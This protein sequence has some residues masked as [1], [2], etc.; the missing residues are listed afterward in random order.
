MMTKSLLSQ[1]GL[2]SAFLLLNLLVCAFSAT[3]LLAE[4]NGLNTSALYGGDVG[5]SMEE[6]GEVNSPLFDE[7]Y[8]DI[9]KEFWNATGGPNWYPIQWDFVGPWHT[10]PHVSINDEGT[11]DIE[12]RA[13]NLRG[14]IPDSFPLIRLSYLA[15]SSNLLS[16]TIPDTFCTSNI[17]SIFLSNNYIGGTLPECLGQLTELSTLS[18]AQNAIEG[19]IPESIYSCKKLDYLVLN[20]NLLTGTLSSGIGGLKLLSALDLSNNFLTGTLPFEITLATSLQQILLSNNLFEGEI[21]RDILRSWGHHVSKLV[22]SDNRFN[23]SLYPFTHLTNTTVIALARNRFTGPLMLIRMLSKIAYLDISGNGMNGTIDPSDFL[24]Y[25]VSDLAY[26]NIMGNNL[27]PIDQQSLQQYPLSFSGDTQLKTSTENWTCKTI[28]ARLI[29]LT[30]MVDPSFLNYS[31][32]GCIRGYFGHPPDNCFP[33]PIDASYC[34][35]GTMLDIPSGSIPYPLPGKDDVLAGHTTPQPVYFEAC[36]SP[37]SCSKKCSVNLVPSPGG[38]RF[39]PE[40][41]ASYGQHNNSLCGCLPGHSGRKCSHCVCDPD[42][43]EGPSCYYEAAMHCRKCSSVWSEKRT[44]AT[45]ISIAFV[46]LIAATITHTLVLRSKRRFTVRSP[47]MSLWKRAIYRILHVRAVGYFKILIIWIQTLAAIVSWRSDV[48][49]RVI[50]F[51]DITNGNAGGIGITCLWPALRHR[52]ISYLARILM[53]FALSAILAISIFFAHFIWNAFFR[54]KNATFKAKKSL[55]NSTSSMDPNSASVSSDS[56]AEQFKINDPAMAALDDGDIALRSGVSESDADDLRFQLTAAESESE[57]LLAQPNSKHSIRYYSARGLIVSE[58]LTVL[59]FF[60]FGV[61]LNS[62]D[63]FPCEEQSGTHVVFL[64]ALPWLRCDSRELRTL[65]ILASP[66]LVLYTLGVPALFVGI[67]LYYRK[68][69]HIR[70]VNDIIGGLYRCYRSSCYGWDIVVL[71]RRF[72]LAL[73]LRI[74]LVTVFH[75]WV[76][77]L[78]LTGSLALQFWFQPFRRE[79]ENRAEEVSLLLLMLTY[80][81]QRDYDTHG[82][83]KDTHA[84]FWVTVL[85]NILFAVSI[86]GLIIHAWWTAKVSFDEDDDLMRENLE[87][88]AGS[89]SF[90]VK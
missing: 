24:L 27:R 34:S 4:A 35:T 28:S 20:G 70:V 64:E 7:A 9:L 44:A 45:G 13:N 17:T 11:V 77:F 52:W 22:L 82:Q 59:Y 67:L 65:R 83:H 23:G 81:A 42:N 1:R 21:P 60:Y 75:F 48:L 62:L 57:L 54:P 47:D 26:F 40:L 90:V 31:H 33:C 12:L 53:P 25:T 72:L 32:C 5:F 63:F 3:A 76:V 79:G 51:I 71:V 55:L 38:G 88:Q 39:V 86:L 58:L 66:T 84:L 56:E 15:L 89:A 68:Q 85:I 61:T 69:T 46:I 19:S 50:S 30:L 10:W 14:T 80:S 78:V 41:V 8:E 18:I 37:L 16:G 43:P 29:G 36:A 2:R 49:Q 74:P 87:D 73:A 6:P